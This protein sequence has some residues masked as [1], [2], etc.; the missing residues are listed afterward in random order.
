MFATSLV[1]R[2]QHQ[3]LKTKQILNVNIRLLPSLF[4]PKRILGNVVP[5]D[6]F[7][8]VCCWYRCLHHHTAVLV[9]NEHASIN[10]NTYD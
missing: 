9:D 4:A 2:G 7:V 1:V 3:I 6:T 10:N 5:I 8:I